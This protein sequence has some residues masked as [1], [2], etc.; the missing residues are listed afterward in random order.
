[1]RRKAPCPDRFSTHLDGE[2][3]AA[4]AAQISRHL[5]DCGECRRI[6]AELRQVEHA[7]AEEPL[8]FLP[9][10]FATRVVA[11]SVGR[12]PVLPLWWVAVPRAW[13][14]GLAGSL[15]A[16][17]FGGTLLGRVLAPTPAAAP[18]PVAE[19]VVALDHPVL[20]ALSKADLGRED[21]P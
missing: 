4:E 16:A 8:P 21:R 7:L 19:I 11:R 5:S 20:A 2:G 1:M 14:I 10:G 9:P 18:P 12:H 6:L 13:R 3:P 15:V 17:A